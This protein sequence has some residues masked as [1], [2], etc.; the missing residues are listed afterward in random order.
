MPL[1]DP[2]RIARFWSKVE[3]LDNDV[4]WNWRGCVGANGYGHFKV[5]ASARGAHVV[6]YEIVKGPVPPDRQVCHSCDNRRCCNP[7]HL[8]LG[9]HKDNADDKVRKGRARGRFS[10]PLTAANLSAERERNVG[11]FPTQPQRET[12][13][14]PRK[15]PRIR[16]LST[17]GAC[18]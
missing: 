5:G 7:F 4:C 9:T 17:G 11:E 12:G 10:A 16:S 14:H 3:V 15:H 13:Q 2:L 1:L 18:I 6:A 8:W